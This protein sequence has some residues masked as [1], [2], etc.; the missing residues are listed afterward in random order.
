ML[1][2]YTC[3]SKR[4]AKT[5]HVEIDKSD[6]ETVAKSTVAAAKSES[7]EE[8]ETKPYFRILVQ[9]DSIQEPGDIESPSS[10]I[11]VSKEP[12]FETPVKRNIQA[13][14]ANEIKQ[15]NK[16]SCPD[17]NSTE[18]HY[19]FILAREGFDVVSGDNSAALFRE[20]WGQ[21]VLDTKLFNTKLKANAFAKT[22]APSPPSTP[23]ASINNVDEEQQTPLS[24]SSEAKLSEVI[25][26]LQEKSQ[27][28]ALFSVTRPTL[29][30]T[31]VL[32]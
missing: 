24:A 19:V 23:M 8:F 26:S 2:H 6:V 32:F 10:V 12:G 5:K 27:A 11:P 18:K 7:Q 22:L 20:E 16:K 17:K 9:K 1:N 21:Y 15:S 28:T 29:P 30:C 25:A 3:S 31:S 4:V 13:D 14:I